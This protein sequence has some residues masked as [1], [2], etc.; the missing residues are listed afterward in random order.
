MLSDNNHPMYEIWPWSSWNDFTV[1]PTVLHQTPWQYYNAC[2][3]SDL[4]RLLF[5]QHIIS[6]ARAAAQIQLSVHACCQ[7]TSDQNFQQ[8]INNKFCMKLEDTESEMFVMLSNAYGTGA[9]KK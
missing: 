3:C 7:K 5:Q 2:A 1:L 4:H 6:S 9:V 8:R